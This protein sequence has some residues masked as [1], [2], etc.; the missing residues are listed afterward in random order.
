MGVPA[1]AGEVSKEGEVS[2][3]QP[4]G[5]EHDTPLATVLPSPASPF[6]HVLTFLRKLGAASPAWK[7]KGWLRKR[8]LCCRRP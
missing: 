6:H 8:V 5:G 2:L 1:L 7:R 4:A 3:L